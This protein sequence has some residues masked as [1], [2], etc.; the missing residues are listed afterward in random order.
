MKEIPD[1]AFE[2]KEGQSGKPKADP[3]ALN[4]EISES[5][6][7]E[8]EEKNG[9]LVAPMGR[10]SI[11][12]PHLADPKA[13]ELEASKSESDVAVVP[14]RAEESFE[15]RTDD[16]PKPVIIGVIEVSDSPP[17]SISS[18]MEMRDTQ[19]IESSGVGAFIGDKNVF[20]GLFTMVEGY[21]ELNASLIFFEA[22]RL[23]KQVI[24]RRLC[25]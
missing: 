6:R 18:P 2:V 19:N 17:G 21:P 16:V 10:W 23:C 5:L 9:S 25:S 8:G 20:K 15:G 14:P 11:V 13:I 24:L 22:E 7:A 3:A 12:V 1:L 4:P